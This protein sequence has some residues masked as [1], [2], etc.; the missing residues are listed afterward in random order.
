MEGQNDWSS[1]YHFVELST[2]ICQIGF[3]YQFLYVDHRIC[4]VFQVDLALSDYG[5]WRDRFRL[6]FLDIVYSSKAHMSLLAG[7]DLF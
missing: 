5:D 7:L 6:F 2:T 4:V 3:E 1:G